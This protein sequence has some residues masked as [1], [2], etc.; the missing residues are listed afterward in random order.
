MHSA[1]AVNAPKSGM[2]SLQFP[3]FK[4]CENGLKAVILLVILSCKS[5]NVVNFAVNYAENREKLWQTASTTIYFLSP[6]TTKIP[7]GFSGPGVN[8]PSAKISLT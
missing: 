7:G 1:F 8:I 4:R 6:D 3:C 2:S 5:L